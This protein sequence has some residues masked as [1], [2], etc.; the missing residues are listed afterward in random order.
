MTSDEL[1][2]PTSG[3]PADETAGQPQRERFNPL[4]NERDMFKVLLGVAVCVAVLL[5][6]LTVARLVF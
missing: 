3:R 1:Q 4:I 5:V 6:A 2:K